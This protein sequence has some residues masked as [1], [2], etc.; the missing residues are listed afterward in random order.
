MEE[1]SGYIV[2]NDEDYAHAYG[3]LQFQIRRVLYV[4]DMYGLG[5]HMTPALDTIMKLVEDWGQRIRGI[6]KPISIEYIRRKR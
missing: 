6:D 4:F 5:V 3:E 1:E 2:L